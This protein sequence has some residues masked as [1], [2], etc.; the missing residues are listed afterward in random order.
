MK[1]TE[2]I[3]EI[4]FTDTEIKAIDG[5]R[6]PEERSSFLCTYMI[7]HLYNKIG[8]L[9]TDPKNITPGNLEA[10]LSLADPVY[11]KLPPVKEG[12][13]AHGDP[14]FLSKLV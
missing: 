13:L 5:A 11:I 6:S 12:P 10:N 2:E 9:K 7:A 8:L 3:P 14:P 1:I 4:G